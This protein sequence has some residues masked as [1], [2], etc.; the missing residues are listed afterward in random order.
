MPHTH[1]IPEIT[2]WSTDRDVHNGGVNVHKCYFCAPTLYPP[3]PKLCTICA[4]CGVFMWTGEDD[5]RNTAMA[6]CEA[7]E[8][9]IDAEAKV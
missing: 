6:V 7:C 8:A 9:E 2:A 3:M 4:K 1:A 5:P